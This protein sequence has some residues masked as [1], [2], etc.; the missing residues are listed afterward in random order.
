MN[1]IWDQKEGIKINTF[2]HHPEEDWVEFT[3]EA[4]GS[5][6]M[7]WVELDQT[8][9]SLFQPTQEQNLI[10]F[11]HFRVE[12]PEIHKRVIK[13]GSVGLIPIGLREN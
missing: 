2:L 9:E 10:G 4:M 8:T 1:P 7:I 6:F 12:H 3:L 5:E 13:E 11:R